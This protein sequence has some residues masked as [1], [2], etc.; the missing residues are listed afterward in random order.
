[1]GFDCCELFTFRSPEFMSAHR[2]VLK[3]GIT[4]ILVENPT[5][6]IMTARFFVKTGT[7]CEPPHLFGLSH[8][9]AAV[10]TKGTGNLSSMDIAEQVESVGASLGA[11][12]TNDYFLFSLKTVS[13]DFEEILNLSAQL[14]RSP[15]LP[16]AEVE[17]EKRLTLQA[18][19]AQKEQPFSIAFSQLREAMYRDH[20]Y[21]VSTLGLENTVAG[22]TRLDLENF[23][24]TYF[25]PDNLIIS[26]VGCWDLDKAIAALEAAFADWTAP[27][28][29]IPQV[30][31]PHL[32]PRP[33]I[34]K[35]AQDTQQAIIMLGYLA[36]S[37]LLK[38]GHQIP[39]EYA[40]LK[41]LNTYLGNGLSSRL[42]VELREKRGLAYDVSAFY[43]TRLDKSQFVVY[44]G[45]APQNTAIAVEGLRVEVERLTAL[46][47]HNDELQTA[48]NKLLGQYALGKQT[49]SQIAQILGWYE[50][51]GLGIEFDEMFPDAIAQVTAEEARRVASR[52]FIDPYI[53]LVGPAATLN[54][55]LP[56][57]IS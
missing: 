32:T 13:S 36:P 18:I 14:L 28:L 1:M 40:A 11:E 29:P 50:T 55:V 51:L 39:P 35:T 34:C 44:M 27:P 26:L 24:R 49:N 7:R 10:M 15:A 4:V 9:L 22:L 3:N 2:V 21:A 45:T 30:D 52:Y 6:D 25:R 23:H 20:P 56:S 54:S 12:T 8:L 48:K 53:S 19:R 33:T 5:A 41:L 47:L 57:P 46:Y 17:L 42:F 16:E 31:L 38:Q 37:V 43:P